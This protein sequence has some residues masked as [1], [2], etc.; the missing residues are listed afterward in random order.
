MSSKDMSSGEAL[1]S[2]TSTSL[3]DSRSGREQSTRQNLQPLGVG[4]LD[5]VDNVPATY[6]SSNSA[7][8]AA[9]RNKQDV[10]C[11]KHSDG[12]GGRRSAPSK[13]L[14]SSFQV[15]KP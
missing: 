15:A 6:S 8:A 12:A 2:S 3:R 9:L 10:T 7:L 1:S 14:R 4:L 5:S 13:H 11:G